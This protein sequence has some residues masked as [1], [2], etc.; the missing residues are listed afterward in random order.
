MIIGQLNE[1]FYKINN[2]TGVMKIQEPSGLLLMKLK[3]EV[4]RL[5]LLHLKF[6]QPTCLAVCGRGDEVACRWHERFGHVNMASLQKLAREE[7]VH[8][9]PGIGQVGQLCEACQAGK[10]RCTLFPMKAEY[11]AERRLELVHGDLCGPISPVTPRGSM[12]FL[13][14]L[15]QCIIGHLNTSFTLKDLGPLHFFLSIHVQH[16]KSS[17]FLHQAKYTKEVLDRVD[18]LKCKPSPTPVNSSP[19]SSTSDGVAT[20]DTSFYR[21]IVGVLQ[22][23]TLTRPDISYVV[24]QVCLYCPTYLLRQQR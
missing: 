17:F 14:H 6:A 22:Y 12:Y 4:N 19:K 18:M 23:L 21:N 11:Q 16:T 15:L 13:L 9:L 2:V 5:Y 3:R 20:P 8:G 10:Q 24:H 1:I 7:V